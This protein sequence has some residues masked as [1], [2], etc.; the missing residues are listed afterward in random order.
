MVSKF[1]SDFKQKFAITGNISCG[2][3]D[4]LLILKKEKLKQML[5]ILF[6]LVLYELLV[7]PI[8]SS[9]PSYFNSSNKWN[10]RPQLQG[11][12]KIAFSKVVFNLLYANAN[13][14]WTHEISRIEFHE[15]TQLICLQS[16]KVSRGC[17]EN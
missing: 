16:K 1:G 17:I 15:I 5:R 2:Q 12:K 14:K 7:T 10:P 8:S 13:F 6:S 11:E 9:S 3:G 4:N